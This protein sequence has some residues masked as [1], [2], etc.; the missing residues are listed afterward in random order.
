VR[1]QALE[2]VAAAGL[3][4]VADQPC[5]RLT[6]GQRR[7][8]DVLLALATPSS[9]LLLDEPAAGLSDLERKQLGATV[10]SLANRGFGFLVVEHDLE[11]AMQIADTV[12]VLAEGRILTKGSPSEVRE[13]PA[14]REV[15]IGERT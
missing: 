13:H 8:V 9:I 1:D 3:H 7:I 6:S 15:L 5:A 11:L 10:R 4:D 2:I 14:V 12:T